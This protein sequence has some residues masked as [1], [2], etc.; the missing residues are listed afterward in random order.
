MSLHEVS[1]RVHIASAP[2]NDC[3]VVMANAKIETCAL[4]DAW[5]SKNHA[6]AR[7]LSTHCS[8]VGKTNFSFSNEAKKL[9]AKD[10]NVH[11]G[12][13]MLLFPLERSCGKRVVRRMRTTPW[14]SSSS[15]GP[16]LGVCTTWCLGPVIVP[17][18]IQP[19]P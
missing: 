11:S 14:P 16:K 5:P 12:E 2:K 18:Y 6:D 7:W 19:G 4:H 17:R 10:L 3:E 9:E 1:Q 15:S 13:G 8:S